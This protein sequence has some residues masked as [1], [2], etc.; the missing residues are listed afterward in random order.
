MG[1][2]PGPLSSHKLIYEKYHSS[3]CSNSFEHPAELGATRPD[4]SPPDEC[5]PDINFEGEEQD[6]FASSPFSDDDHQ[7]LSEMPSGLDEVWSKEE[8]EDTVPDDA[9]VLS[10]QCDQSSGWSI[11]RQA[12]NSQSMGTE[13]QVNSPRVF[14]VRPH[15][16]HDTRVFPTYSGFEVLE[17]PCRK[18]LLG[19]TRLF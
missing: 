8:E 2:P 10:A 6:G 4:C 7:K 18:R 5:S 19:G 11:G 13:M 9:I 1:R 15:N 16:L 3:S 17:L 12:F 14:Q